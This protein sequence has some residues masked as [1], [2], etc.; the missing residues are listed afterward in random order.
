MTDDER[1]D[2]QMAG[3]LFGLIQAE[4]KFGYL[5]MHVDR[6]RFI[7]YQWSFDAGGKPYGSRL[8][9]DPRRHRIDEQGPI[10]IFAERIVHDWKSFHRGCE[11]KAKP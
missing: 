7:V 3:E 5:T 1:K 4:I 8:V 9:F 10:E 6:N 11:E 2:Y